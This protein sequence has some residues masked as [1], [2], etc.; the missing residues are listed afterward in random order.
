MTDR[1]TSIAEDL[2]ERSAR[3]ISRRRFLRRAGGAVA[4][5]SIASVVWRPGMAWAEC[6]ARTDPFNADRICGPSPYCSS[7]RCY[8]SGRCHHS[9]QHRARTYGGNRCVS[10]ITDYSNCWCVCKSGNLYRCCDCCA[11]T[12]QGGITD[13][14]ERA[15]CPTPNQ[16]WYECICRGTRCTGCC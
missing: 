7:T 13:Y 5:A 16:G 10:E 14:C 11:D 9:T 8:D 15:T 4:A 2:V 3:G 1:H 6:I 12:Y